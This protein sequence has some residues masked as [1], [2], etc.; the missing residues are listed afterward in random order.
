MTVNLEV[1]TLTGVHI[2]RKHRNYSKKSFIP[3]SEENTPPPAFL[4]RV[5]ETQA[6]NP[7]EFLESILDRDL[8][9]NFRPKQ[10][11]KCPKLA[12][13]A[14]SQWTKEL[15]LQMTTTSDNRETINDNIPLTIRNMEAQAPK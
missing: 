1:M 14:N 6:E 7:I 12:K 9:S 8:E 5:K 3:W 15:N 10:P 4:K 11:C 13:L 2:Y